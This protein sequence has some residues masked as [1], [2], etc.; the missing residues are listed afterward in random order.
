MSRKLVKTSKYVKP[1]YEG[2]ENLRRKVRLRIENYLEKPEIS[3]DKLAEQLTELLGV[4]YT[5]KPAAGLAEFLGYPKKDKKLFVENRNRLNN[6]RF[7][8]ERK[9]YRKNA[10]DKY[11]A[12]G[13]L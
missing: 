10:F 3:Q 12:A 1:Y 4:E 8:E 11:V 13:G 6:E 9:M 5:R 7:A 2:D